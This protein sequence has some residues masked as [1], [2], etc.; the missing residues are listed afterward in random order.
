MSGST[1]T[2][3]ASAANSGGNNNNNHQGRAST[4]TTPIKSRSRKKAG[5]GS[6][7]S[8]PLSSSMGGSTGSGSTTTG[9][10][11]APTAGDGIDLQDIPFAKAG[12]KPL[13]KPSG[14]MGE[15]H[16]DGTA[17]GGDPMAR[18]RACICFWRELTKTVKDCMWTEEHTWFYVKYH[19]LSKIKAM[20]SNCE[21]MGQLKEWLEKRY[22]REVTVAT[23][24]AR[25]YALRQE[26]RSFGVYVEEGQQVWREVCDLLPGQ[27]ETAVQVWVGNLHESWRRCNQTIYEKLKEC[28]SWVQVEDVEA[29]WGSSAMSHETKEPAPAPIQRNPVAAAPRAVGGG[30]GAREQR[31]GPGCWICGS[32]E[33][34]KR[35][36]PDRPPRASEPR[37]GQVGTPAAAGQGKGKG[38][39]E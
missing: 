4:Y 13:Q 16:W 1:G 28:S 14:I 9:T 37:Q 33:H 3:G 11:S 29:E 21:S 19:G 34:R 6:A 31:V 30:G 35:E 36:C 12:T 32:M 27:E 5:T 26:G 15:A 2:N 8:A 7:P 20:A 25:I 38:R 17:P 10:T 24:T 39:S 22:I 23:L 18:A